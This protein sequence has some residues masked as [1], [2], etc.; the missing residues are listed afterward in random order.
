MQKSCEFYLIEIKLFCWLD[1]MK[2]ITKIL[3]TYTFG[4]WSEVLFFNMNLLSG[5]LLFV[6]WG[7]Y[8]DD[9]P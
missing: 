3:V 2:Q 4:Y 1:Q 5:A 6:C 8:G 9:H 7:E